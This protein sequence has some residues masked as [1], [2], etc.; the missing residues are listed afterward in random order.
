MVAKG[1]DIMLL[2]K[3]ET[4]TKRAVLKRVA[5]DAE[6]TYLT[7]VLHVCTYAGTGVIIA[8]TYNA[9]RVACIGRQ[10]AQVNAIGYIVACHELDGYRQMLRDDLVHTAFNLGNLL[11]GGCTGQSVVALALLALDM[12]ITAALASEHPHHSLVKDVLHGVHRRVL[13]FVMVV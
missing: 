5:Y 3:L 9:Q 6:C 11:H 12:R 8:H 4:Q 1:A 13:G 10:L 2:C 7:C